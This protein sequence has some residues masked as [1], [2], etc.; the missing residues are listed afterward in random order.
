[1]NL[2]RTDKDG[3]HDR[4]KLANT[5]PHPKPLTADLH[6]V[7]TFD[8]ERLLP[9]TVGDWVSDEAARMPCPPE[10]VAVAALVCLGSV[11]GTRCGVRPKVRDSWIVIPNLWG[12]IVGDPSSKK[13]PAWSSATKPLAAVEAV[14][15]DVYAKSN[16]RR[17]AEK[18]IHE[19][20]GKKIERDLKQ[21]VDANNSERIQ[22]LAE[23]L[24]DHLD[25]ASQDPRPPR[26]RTSD[27]TVESLGELLRDNPRGILVTRDELMGLFATW[28][29]EGH[30]VD[31][32]FF[33]ECWNGT[34]GFDSDRIGRG[35]IRVENACVSILG[36]IQPDKL[37][38]YLNRTSHTI[39]NDGL[40]QRLQML[41]YPD[42]QVWAWR[43]RPPNEHALA[44]A[45]ELFEFAAS[46]DPTS[47]GARPAN[48][49]IGFPHFQF[50]EAGQEIFIEWAHTLYNETISSE[51]DSLLKQH[52]SKYE[53]L[54]CALAVI[55]HVVDVFERQ[56]PAQIGESAVLH[57]REWCSLLYHHAR[58]CY[59]LIADDGL[60]AAQSLAGKLEQ[61]KL[62]DGFT[63]R[64]V[65]RNQWS[66]LK[67][68]ESVRAA[69]EWLEDENWIR[70]SLSGGE[71]FASGRQTLRYE[72]NPWIG[73]IRKTTRMGGK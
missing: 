61:R 39:G 51:T 13:T 30:E 25:G 73:E 43:D 9:S 23:N 70:S 6:S 38:R 34:Q 22:V 66:S 28:E 27:A 50:S 57:A 20:I 71:T 42:P 68:S 67:T 14:Q 63:L 33:L 60:R 64:D 16:R 58:R 21:A 18:L 55:F 1:M 17:R 47:F 26:F 59:G 69:L 65:R 46:F 7:P 40:F 52:L 62:N 49:T 10:Y 15:A 4:D 3:G 35:H 53:K 37:Y 5:W 54:F 2:P 12:A 36:G 44:R 32:A 29:K 31:R 56:T 11:L 48:E 8:V 45:T 24:S 19:T 72:I 41:V